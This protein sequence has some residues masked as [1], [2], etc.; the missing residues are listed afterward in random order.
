MKRR[1]SNKTGSNALS[2]SIYVVLRQVHP[3]LGISNQAMAIMNSLCQDLTLRLFQEATSLT[4]MVGK[5]TLTACEVQTATRLVLPGDL[6]KYAVSEATK[7][8]AKFSDATEKGS[9]RKLAGLQFPVSYL[10]TWMQCRS[11]GR[12][13]KTAPI[14]LACVI[15]Y[16]CAEVLE[17]AGNAAKDFKTKRIVPRHI[18]LT[19]RGDEEL[20]VLLSNAILPY[21]GVIPHI[22]KCLRLLVAT[23]GWCIIPKHCRGASLMDQFG[24]TEAIPLQKGQKKKRLYWQS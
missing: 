12:I 13:S 4:E 3:D 7:A 9:H 16:L 21:A 6:A 11:T 8:V 18:M 2:V 20:D 15:E 23:N 14:Y 24:F 1:R 10:R 17:L 5:K 22:H 19:V